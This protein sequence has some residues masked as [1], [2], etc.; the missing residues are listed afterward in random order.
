MKRKFAMILVIIA[1]S[2]MLT[3]EPTEGGGDAGTAAPAGTKPHRHSQQE[4]Q[5]QRQKM[6]LIK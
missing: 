4:I 2:I 6:K 1:A 5:A 3:G